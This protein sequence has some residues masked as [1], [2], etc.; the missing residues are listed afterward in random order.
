MAAKREFEWAGYKVIITAQRGRRSTWSNGGYG[1]TIL[2]LS[3]GKII[4][5]G[6]SGMETAEEAI[7][8]A[9][10]FVQKQMDRKA[11]RDANEAAETARRQLALQTY[12]ACA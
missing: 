3:D 2:R 1:A 10:L 9:G 11:L 12:S 6:I 8:E 4:R 5:C 7:F